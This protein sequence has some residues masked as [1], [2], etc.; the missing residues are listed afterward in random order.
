MERGDY[1]DRIERAGYSADHYVFVDETAS[2][3]CD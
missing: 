1:A 3:T 2:N